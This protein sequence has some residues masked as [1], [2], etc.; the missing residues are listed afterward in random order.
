[1]KLEKKMFAFSNKNAS[2]WKG[3]LSLKIRIHRKA[4]FLAEKC[5]TSFLAVN[6]AGK[7]SRAANP[8]FLEA[9]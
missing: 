2:T 3:S 8:W 1:M 4:Q 5:E 7:A 6:L 9:E